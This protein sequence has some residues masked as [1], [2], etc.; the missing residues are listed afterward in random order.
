[1]WRLI[2]ALVHNIPVDGEELKDLKYIIISLKTK[3][4]PTRYLVVFVTC[5]LCISQDLFQERARMSSAQEANTQRL[6]S[7]LRDKETAMKVRT[8]ETTHHNITKWFCCRQSSS[9][10]FVIIWHN[11]RPALAANESLSQPTLQ[12]VKTAR[13]SQT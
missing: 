11:F 10:S 1:M 9:T 5:Y 3:I 12:K 4:E 7:A 6:M 13:C 2:R 8:L